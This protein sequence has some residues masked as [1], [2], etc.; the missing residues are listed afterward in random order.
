MSL[1][2]VA[3]TALGGAALVTGLIACNTTSAADR[4]AD[5]TSRVVSWQKAVEHVGQRVRVCGPLRSTGS[6]GDDRFL[7]LGAS[8]PREPRFTIVVWDN[9]AS[10]PEV[11]NRLRSYRACATGKVSMYGSVPQ[12]ELEDGGAIELLKR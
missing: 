1:L 7:N 5:T 3:A 12:M 2:R 6:D 11:G 4:D 9:P 10:V 8:Y